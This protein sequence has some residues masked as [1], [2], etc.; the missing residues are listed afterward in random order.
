MTLMGLGSA[1]L[2]MSVYAADAEVFSSATAGF[3][4]TKP[5][6]WQFATADQNLE[7]LKRT[8]LNDKEFHAAMVK[9]ATAPLVVM[10][11]Y[12]EPFE[13][14]NPTLKVNIKPFGQLKGTAPT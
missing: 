5:A 10:M 8:E 13:D 2:A 14:L 9:Y 11:K 3:E 1:L 7:N 4:V 6:E 12:P